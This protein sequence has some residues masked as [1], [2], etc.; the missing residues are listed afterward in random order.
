[1]LKKLKGAPGIHCLCMHG[2]PAFS[3]KLGSHGI[4]LSVPWSYIVGS[5]HVM[6]MSS[7]KEVA[8]KQAILYALGMVGN[9][10]LCWRTNKHWW[11]IVFHHCHQ[12]YPSQE[13]WEIFQ[14]TLNSE[15]PA[16]MS[17]IHLGKAETAQQSFCHHT[18]LTRLYTR[19]FT[20]YFYLL[21]Q[22][23][24]HSHGQNVT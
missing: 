2:Y 20:K 19:I 17:C 1:M 8:F 21:A 23:M 12:E 22:L 11:P 13:T 3:G 5:S 16:S 18:S 24:C 7:G 10:E 9:Q 4:C 15:Q 14:L 6:V